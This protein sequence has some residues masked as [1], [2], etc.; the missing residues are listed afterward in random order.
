MTERTVRGQVAVAGVGES[1]YYKRGQ[2]PEPEIK[3]GLHAILAACED[4]GI[5]PKEID[6]FC[7][8]SDDRNDP[9]RLAAALGVPELRLSVMQWGGGGGVSPSISWSCMK[10]TTFMANICAGDISP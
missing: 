2:S 8:F 6:G 9:T 10:R 7:S 3:L 5:S 4:A 1:A